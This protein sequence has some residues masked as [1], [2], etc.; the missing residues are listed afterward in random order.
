MKPVNRQMERSGN[1]SVHSYK[2]AAQEII[3]ESFDRKLAFNKFISLLIVYAQDGALAGEKYYGNN[4][5]IKGKIITSLS[6]YFLSIELKVQSPPL[7][8]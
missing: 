4:M 8:S 7:Q 3:L 6:R 1:M 2:K 5:V